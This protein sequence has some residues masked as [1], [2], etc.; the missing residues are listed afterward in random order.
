MRWQTFVLLSLALAVTGCGRGRTTGP[1]DD[2]NAE[3]RRMMKA[4]RKLNAMSPETVDSLVPRLHVGMSRA[5]VEQLL[6]EKNGVDPKTGRQVGTLE[7][8]R[9]AFF[10]KDEKGDYVRDA[11]GEPQVDPSKWY[12]VF[13][14]KD[15]DLTVV[16]N[17]QE[18]LLSWSAEPLRE[19]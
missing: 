12:L 6:M 3:I 16:F 10:L 1:D 18:R 5:E 4:G 2:S 8:G 9:G 17:N 7:Y 19:N 14:L 15:G 13:L 11:N